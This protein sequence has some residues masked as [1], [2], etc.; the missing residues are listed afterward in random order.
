MSS[1]VRAVRAAADFGGSSWVCTTLHYTTAK[2]ASLVAPLSI[3]NSRVCNSSE[4]AIV[5]RIRLYF[6]LIVGAA[7]IMLTD[8]KSSFFLLI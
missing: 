4:R 1:A 7:L 8:T 5:L 2:Q 6:V 3:F